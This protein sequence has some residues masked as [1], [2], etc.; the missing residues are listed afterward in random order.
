MTAAELYLIDTCYKAGTSQEQTQWGPGIEKRARRQ[1]PPGPTVRARCLLLGSE[2]GLSSLSWPTAKKVSL[3]LWAETW[4]ESQLQMMGP[5][6]VPE[7]QLAAP[8]PRWWP[9][10]YSLSLSACGSLPWVHHL[11]T[12]LYYWKCRDYLKLSWSI[13]NCKNGSHRLDNNIN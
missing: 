1:T 6:E 3:S 5:A 13:D 12:S 10:E 11:L 4:Q 9:W 8:H 2:W 7:A